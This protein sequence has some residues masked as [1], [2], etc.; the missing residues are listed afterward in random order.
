MPEN[1]RDLNAA[2]LGELELGVGHR[3]R[4]FENG[5]VREAKRRV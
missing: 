4:E 1:Q 2:D 3:A 5:G